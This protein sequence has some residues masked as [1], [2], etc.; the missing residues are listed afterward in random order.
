MKKKHKKI[1]GAVAPQQAALPARRMASA[2]KAVHLAA[3]KAL[4]YYSTAMLLEAQCRPRLQDGVI[5]V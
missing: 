3:G 2:R 5:R 1:G 4:P